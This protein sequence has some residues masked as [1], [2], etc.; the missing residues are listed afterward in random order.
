MHWSQPPALPDISLK[1]LRGMEDGRTKSEG[2]CVW[3]EAGLFFWR[4]CM[5]LQN[6]L[7]VAPRRKERFHFHYPFWVI[8]LPS[9]MFLSLQT[10][11]FWFRKCTDKPFFSEP[12]SSSAPN[13]RDES[14]WSQGW[15]W[16]LLSTGETLTLTSAWGFSK[17]TW[18]SLFS[19]FQLLWPRDCLGSQGKKILVGIK[20]L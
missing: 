19:A 20:D 15:K 17:T 10:K 7:S 16:K 11:L 9:G 14:E 4:V 12:S 5:P 1:G 8:L 18:T 3:R 2:R 13:P 6:Q